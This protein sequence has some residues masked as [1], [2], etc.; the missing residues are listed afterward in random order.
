LSTDYG[1]RKTC[2]EYLKISQLSTPFLYILS[3]II[4]RNNTLTSLIHLLYI[5]IQ[6]SF[7]F[8]IEFVRLNVG[9][10]NLKVDLKIRCTIDL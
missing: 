7:K 10:M 5:Y 2:S 3:V 9:S 4:T 8:T 1:H 6:Q